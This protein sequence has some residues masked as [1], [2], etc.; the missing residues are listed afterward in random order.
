MSSIDDA[1]RLGLRDVATR[2]EI[3]IRQG[4]APRFQNGAIAIAAIAN[5]RV[6]EIWATRDSKVGILDSE[7]GIASELPILRAHWDSKDDSKSLPSNMLELRAD[8]AFVSFTKE[9]DGTLSAFGANMLK[10]VKPLL[11]RVGGW[12]PGQLIKV[13]YFDRYLKS[14]LTVRLACECIA[15][16]SNAIG[17]TTQTQTQVFLVSE[18]WRSDSRYEDRQPWQ[19]RHDWQSDNDRIMAT[20]AIAAKLGLKGSLTLRRDRH[21]REMILTFDDFKSVTLVFDQG[22]GS[23]SGPKGIPL[24]FDFGVKAQEQATKLME[25]KAMIQGPDDLSYIV[26]HK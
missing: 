24:R 15:A 2:Y 7:W 5:D 11:Q 14:P 16:L 13:E 6:G 25:L 4:T 10:L 8:A 9:C 22:F 23:W 3:T 1:T 18:P 26:V 21:A 12:R 20:E 17:S 19:V